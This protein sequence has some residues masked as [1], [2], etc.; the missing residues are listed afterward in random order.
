M[1]F[2]ESFS[3]G[4]N[5]LYNALEQELPFIGLYVRRSS[6]LYSARLVISE[7]AGTEA[8]NVFPDPASWYLV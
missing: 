8:W 5:D 4:L 1:G 7:A 2:A 3:A 6:L